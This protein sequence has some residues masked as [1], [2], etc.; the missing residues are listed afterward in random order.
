MPSE[1]AEEIRSAAVRAGDHPWVE[2]LARA[3]YVVTGVVHALIAWIALQLAWGNSSGQAA[4]QSGALQQ[5]AQSPGGAL[6]LWVCAVGL[7][8]LALVLL[9]SAVRPGVDWPDRAKELGRAVVYGVLAAAAVQ[10][11]TGSGGAKD[12]RQSSV[13]ATRSLMRLPF[14]AVI[15]GAVAVGILAVGGYHIYKGVTRRFLRD[16]VDDPGR[17]G[18]WSGAVGYVAKGIALLLVGGLFGYAAATQDPKEATGL[19]GGLRTLLG[20]PA[21]PWLLT[22]VALGLAA[23]GVYSVVRAKYARL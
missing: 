3:G 17:L 1:Y 6:I 14:G 16:L 11:A 12:T 18:R 20:T 2:R 15:V 21:G 22:L 19:D 8:M 10:F 23:Y 13:D 5:L 9:T 4:D 7:A